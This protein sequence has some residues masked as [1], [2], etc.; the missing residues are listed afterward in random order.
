MFTPAT[1]HITKPKD[2]SP[3]TQ[4]ESST[5]IQPKTN[6]SESTTET[7]KETA[8]SA[9]NADTKKTSGDFFAPAVQNKNQSPAT[10]DSGTSEQAEEQQEVT[11]EDK[12]T[13]PDQSTIHEGVP[14]QNKPDINGTSDQNPTA[15]KGAP[16]SGNKGS[17]PKAGK[18]VGTPNGKSATPNGKNADK[19]AQKGEKEGEADKEAA[20][21]PTENTKVYADSLVAQSPI[22]FSRSVK[23]ADKDAAQAQTSEK[24]T[25]KESLPEIEQPT[26][27]PIKS[28][29]TTE[30]TK[31]KTAQQENQLQ[32]QKESLPDTTPQGKKE[33][34]K[35]DEKNV[36]PPSSFIEK[37]KSF[38]SFFG[39]GSDD[40]K[41][42]EIKSSIK[43]LPTSESVDTNPGTAPQVDLT[44]QADPSK[45]E[46]NN[47]AADTSVQ[48]DQTKNLEE[49]KIYKGEDDIYPEMEIEML[50]PTTEM[51]PVDVN[52][53][54]EKEI[55]Q[56]S[57]E[58]A[59][60]FDASAKAY[61][62]KELGPEKAKQDEAFAKMETDQEQERILTDTKIEQETE[63]VKKEQ[64][65]EQQKAK[66]EVSKQRSDWQKENEAVK[67]EFSTKSSTAKK[68]AD[69]DI[70]TKTKETDKKVDEEYT[71]AKTEGDK[72]VTDANKA[73]KDKKA[74]AKKESENKSWWDRAVDAVSSF[75]DKLKEALNTLF[76]GLRKL[77]KG[78]IEAAKK[79]ANT[80]IDLARDAIVGM[81]KAFGEALKGLVNIAL[82]A[83]PK[84]RDKFNAAIDAAV[85]TAVNVVNKL[86]ES[87]KKAVN[88]LLDALGAVL[89]AIL[90]AYQALYNLFLD[91]L[92]FLTI[93]L[94][95]IL[96]FLWNLVEGAWYAPGEFLGALAK[97]AI[98][99]DPSK[100]LPNFEVPEGQEENWAAAMGVPSGKTAMDPTQQAGAQIPEQLQAVLSKNEL[101]SSDVALEPNPAV[102]L[103]PEI[104]QEISQY[105]EGTM[106]LGG[107]GGEAITTKE[108]QASA[109]DANGYDISSIG[110]TSA[111][112]AAESVN[113]TQATT[114]A[115][116]EPVEDSSGGSSPD[117]RN[118]SDDQKLDHYLKQM[119]KPNEDAASKQPA[120]SGQKAAPVTNNSPE[121]LIT[122]TGRLSVGQRLAFMGSQMMTGL[123]VLWNKY[124]VW[125]IT[126]LV[127]ALLAAGV[128]A[129]F[130]GGA[131]LA[132]AVDIIV[133]A[134]IVI[135]GAIAVYKAVG[136]IWDY[137]K[138]A[139]VGDTKKAGQSL[140]SAIAVIVVEFFIDKILLGMAKVFKRI[141]KAAKAVMK[142]TK[143]GRKILAGATKAR[144][145]VGTTVRKGVAKVK[146]AKL[147]VNMQGRIGKG[148]KKLSDLRQRILDKFK[149]KKFKLVIKGTKWQLLGDFN[150][151]VLIIEGPRKGEIMEVTD[152]NNIKLTRKKHILDQEIEI[153]GLKTKL[154]SSE[155][156][157]H[158][159]PGD[160]DEL[161][162]TDLD[163]F[164]STYKERYTK[165]ANLPDDYA[166]SLEN[167]IWDYGRN[168]WSVTQYYD[169]LV[170]R[171]LY[172]K[173]TINALIA[174]Y[175]H[176]NA[177][178]VHALFGYTTNFIY[179]KLNKALRSGKNLDEIAEFKN[180]LM[181]SM[182]KI[183]PVPGGAVSYRGLKIS[184]D[185]L[186]DFAR[187]YAQGNNV[188]EKGFS[189]AAKTKGDAF[190]GDDFNVQMT[191]VSKAD[192]SG[193]DISDFAYGKVEYGTTSEILFFPDSQF[194][195]IGFTRDGNKIHLIM[196]EI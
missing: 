143:T 28:K 195:I 25:L 77:V 72:K 142:S 164:I 3:F 11:T 14:I 43:K 181:K 138:Y 190:S 33:G 21:L 110:D 191:M 134:M 123:K 113:N 52:T 149:F 135:F 171:G 159:L 22:A 137:V 120:P 56:V 98:G 129:F 156:G 10:S 187:K 85:N 155:H 94:L 20:I 47:Q 166:R 40:S 35:V 172:P 62:D 189:S 12:I 112:Q 167:T 53:A 174:K 61:M 147:V 176:L 117:W 88:A 4:K 186:D 108:F 139:W 177:D 106:E 119:T 193:R 50:S 144:R 81:I 23:T 125:I 146:G 27:I 70:D 145:F 194:K 71:K 128:I 41:K 29:A 153:D 9:D 170:K 141:V 32:G 92:K 162:K 65:S 196:Q 49:S 168:N 38:F 127:T 57:P 154:V 101:A 126:A 151:Y 13:A 131:G 63:N 83:F 152:P 82:A 36:Q 5:F 132:L 26:G 67:S 1:Q 158:G 55:P 90:A 64:E 160:L 130:T 15:K 184:P 157:R 133:K 165:P 102:E 16:D 74:K 183:D 34:K 109:A 7:D 124:K 75:F 2:N 87:L 95:K 161:R 39:S 185:D 30:K 31:Q 169:N 80:L 91:F 76:D 24:N 121:A 182:K 86:A 93:G 78:L 116:A 51:S 175:K 54:L 79:L 59:Q 118:W 140:A 163:Q 99:G 150:P 89:D 42:S 58:V 19:G 68:K 192:G 114:D 148:V 97:E 107:A 111:P 73:A 180:L 69:K 37:L 136:H 8:P 103:S 18:G 179:K 105:P 17:V 84:L 46:E 66:G 60:S 122:K 100:P 48:K 188:T 104:L 44:G 6:T 178:D 173:D 45:N 96:E 115:T